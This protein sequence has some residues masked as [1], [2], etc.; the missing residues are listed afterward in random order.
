M[1]SLPSV[2]STIFNNLCLWYFQFS[3][4]QGL[5]S[6][7]SQAKPK[8]WTWRSRTAR[9]SWHRVGGTFSGRPVVTWR[10][11]V[12]ISRRHLLR[13]C[14]RAGGKST[15]KNPGEQGVTEFRRRQGPQHFAFFPCN[16][17]R[18]SLYLLYDFNKEILSSHE[19]LCKN[20]FVLR[21]WCFSEI[22]S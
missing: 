18:K 19:I 2:Y 9:W 15:I 17:Q 21:I 13:L 16:I 11:S 14:L 10:D 7:R 12:R 22:C 6:R 4:L 1:C 8:F 3:G 20:N 5:I